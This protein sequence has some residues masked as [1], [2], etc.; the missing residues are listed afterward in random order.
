MKQPEGFIKLNDINKVCKLNKA[1]YGL[2]VFTNQRGKAGT[3]RFFR[4][5]ARNS[6]AF[7]PTRQIL[8]GMTFV[9]TFP[10]RI[11]RYSTQI[12]NIT[13]NIRT[14]SQLNKCTNTKLYL[15]QMKKLFC[16]VRHWMMREES[17][18]E[19]Y[20]YTYFMYFLFLLS[21][22]ILGYIRIYF[23]VCFI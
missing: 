8:G 3:T 20:Y 1:I 15:H 7:T 2:K 17:K 5:I 6:F 12:H 9:P 4:A 10:N 23:S 22:R 14:T 18:Y 16:Y 11:F 21:N 13:N 19:I